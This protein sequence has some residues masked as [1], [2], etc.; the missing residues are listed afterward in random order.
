MKKYFLGGI[1]TGFLLFGMLGFASATI[2]ESKINMDNGY[3]IFLS[4]DDSVQGISFGSLNDWYTTDTRTTNLTAG[5]DYYLH[6][7][8]YNQGNI[9]G[10]LGEFSLSGSDHRFA[11]DTTSLLTNTGD[12]SG[13]NSGWGS[14]YTALVD[15]GANGSSSPWGTT[16]TN[17]IPNTARWIW[18][19]DAG[20]NSKTY[21]STTISAVSA[22]SAPAPIPE[23]ATMFLLGIGLIGA[24]RVGRR[25]K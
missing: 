21:F 1:V 6:V 23:P 9:A 2:L 5:T 13:N 17:A 16:H 3:E 20:S 18:G 14:S 22:T 19:G 25:K 11:N 10:F 7:Y 4:T 15:L 24:A 12:W 8:G